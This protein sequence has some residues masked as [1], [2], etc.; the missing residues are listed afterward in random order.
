MKTF[1]APTRTRSRAARTNQVDAPVSK[2][3]VA[4]VALGAL[5]AGLIVGAGIARL[6]SPK[7]ATTK[8]VATVQ[9]PTGP[10]PVGAGPSRFDGMVP[11]GYQHN[12]AGAVAAAASFTAMT[13][14]MLFRPE[15][16]AR[17]AARSIATPEAADAVEAEAMKPIDGIRQGFA[18]AGSR[19]PDGR[20]LVRTMP[21]GTRVVS[22]DAER[23]R[24]E[25]WSMSLIAIELDGTGKAGAQPA[26]QAVF[27]TSSY[28]LTWTAGDWHVQELKSIDD[29]GPALTRAAPLTPTPFI[30][31][32]S[33]FVPFRYLAS[34]G[35]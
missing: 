1:T 3:L 20:A 19:N 21:I 11:V 16:E 30:D 32:A 15:Y 34:R 25:V 26:T 14:E 2:R 12:E 33:T 23:T 6:Q 29:S 22:Y 8:A 17:A 7:A 10:N 13:T 5:G 31:Q 24:I 28:V 27:T 4:L 18:L 9:A 35:S